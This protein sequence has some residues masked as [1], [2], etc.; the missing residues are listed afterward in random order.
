MFFKKEVI[1]NILKSEYDAVSGFS[2]FVGTIVEGCLRKDPHRRFGVAD[3]LGLEGWDR[4]EDFEIDFRVCK[5]GRKQLVLDLEGSV[6][7]GGEGKKKKKKKKK[8]GLQKKFNLHG[9]SKSISYFKNGKVREKEEGIIFEDKH[10]SLKLRIPEKNSKKSDLSSQLSN[11]IFS[12]TNKNN[13]LNNDSNFNFSNNRKNIKNNPPLTLTKKKNNH[14]DCQIS[15]P[16]SPQNQNL[17]SKIFDPKKIS[18]SRM[19]MTR[20]FLIEKLGKEKYEKI[21]NVYI[22]QNCTKEKI[23]AFLKE[24]EKGYY[25]LLEYTFKNK[26]PSTQ[27]SSKISDLMKNF[28][29]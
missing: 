7:F 1:S 16:Y 15:L 17:S 2:R 23:L 20:N 4:F 11:K 12:S 19:M 9:Y 18:H 3:I 26:T 25:K 14:F 6:D 10:K 28:K 24:E 5:S 22:S 8:G 13:C 29:F 27:Y 21:K